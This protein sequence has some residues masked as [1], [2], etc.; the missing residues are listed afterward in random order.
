VADVIAELCG[1][2]GIESEAEQQEFSLYCIVQGDAFTMPLAADEYILDVTT[3]LLKSGQPF[4]LIFC[5]SVWHF[6]LKRDPAPTPLYIEVLFNQV[7]P[8]YLEGL[9]LELPSGGAPNPEIV[10]DMARIAAI[11]HRAADLNHIPVMKEIKFLLPKP[12]LGLREIRP[13]QWVSLV[14]SA[15]PTIA[16]LNPVQ[17]KAQFLNVLASWHL[18]GSSFF[19]VKRVWAEDGPAEEASS[20]WKE[21]I[22]ALNRRGVLFL[23]PNTHETMQHWPFTEVIST[24]K[25]SITDFFS[26]FCRY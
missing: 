4:Y 17:V 2:L 21:L 20:L 8:D 12:A 11:L 13:A 24:R 19:A 14:Q 15:W 5:R 9:L 22:L 6:A 7:A 10:R 26:Y 25:V 16:N 1:L 23:D 18:F 3:E